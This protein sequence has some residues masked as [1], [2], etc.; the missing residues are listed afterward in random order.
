[1]MANDFDECKEIQHNQW[2]LPAPKA[3]R[4]R[5]TNPGNGRR[6]LYVGAHAQEVIGMPANEGRALLEDLTAFCT[7]P[8]F[9][10][11]AMGGAKATW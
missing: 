2:R 5:I 6:N 3:C 7:Q 4:A 10:Y 11:T 1:M 8:Q 9:V